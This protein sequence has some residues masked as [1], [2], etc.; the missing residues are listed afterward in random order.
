MGFSFLPD[1]SN[2]HKIFEDHPLDYKVNRLVTWL[3]SKTGGGGG[4][5][6]ERGGIQ[7]FSFKMPL[8]FEAINRC[9]LKSKFCKEQLNIPNG[10]HFRFSHHLS[11]L[12]SVSHT[13]PKEV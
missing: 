7:D 4:G 3:L 12:K 13:L 5:G 11:A 8:L 1:G 2:D 9:V 10:S 6:G